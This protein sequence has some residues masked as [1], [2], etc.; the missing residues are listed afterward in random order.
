MQLKLLIEKPALN[1]GESQ[2]NI[3]YKKKTTVCFFAILIK[4]NV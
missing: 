4:R 2:D 1:G 3:L